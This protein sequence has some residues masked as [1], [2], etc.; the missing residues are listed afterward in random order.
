MNFMADHTFD[1]RSSRRRIVVEVD[2]AGVPHRFTLN[3]VPSG[4]T[5]PCRPGFQLFQGKRCRPCSAHPALDGW[6]FPVTGRWVACYS[7]RLASAFREARDAAAGSG[8]W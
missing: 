6:A 3:L 4:W 5:S 2:F 1:G 7:V 8:D